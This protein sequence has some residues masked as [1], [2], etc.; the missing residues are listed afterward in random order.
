MPNELA[1]DEPLKELFSVA[2]RDV[3][4]RFDGARPECLPD[5]CRVLQHPLLD[6]R[7]RIEPC[8]D[9]ATQAVGQ[10]L[11]P[12]VLD[13]HSTELFRVQRVAADAG[14]Q[15]LVR[16]GRNRSPLE[17]RG[18]QLGGTAPGQGRY[19]DR[20]HARLAAGPARSALEQLRSCSRD[21]EEGHAADLLDHL[22]DEVEECVVCPVHVLEDEHERALV[23]EGLQV[24][25]PGREHLAA[26]I[27]DRGLLAAK[28]DERAQ[29]GRDPAGLGR[30][31]DHTPNRRSQ[32]VVGLLGCV[33]LE[34]PR[35]RLDH[36]AERP[37]ADAV[38]VG[39]RATLTPAHRLAG[40]FADLPQLGDQAGLADA[41]Y[42]QDR[43]ELG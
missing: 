41:R 39:E 9:D 31:L 19:R 11:E 24:T 6:V 30:I 43:D 42:P 21:D 38:A 33:A 18:D 16:L 14:K 4:D 34:D 32:L 22:V 8:R 37:E 29:E 5:D 1:A 3:A 23:R 7:Q 26:A 15:G 27:A 40:T 25:S 13:E 20:Q 12:A 36:L 2:A 10:L 35:L 17:E 28:T